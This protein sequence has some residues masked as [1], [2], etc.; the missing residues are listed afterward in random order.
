MFLF[1]GFGIEHWYL[2]VLLKMLVR[3]LELNRSG[4]SFALEPALHL[5]RTEREQMVLFYQRG[6]RIEILDVEVGDFLQELRR[7]FEAAGGFLEAAATISQRPRIFISYER[8]DSGTAS[9][10]FN[11]LQ[12]A[13]FEVWLDEESLQGGEEWNEIIEDQLK[14]CDYVVLLHSQNLVE[15]RE[16]YINKEIA[17][18]LDRSKFFRGIFLI[19]LLMH[20]LSAKDGLEKIKNLDQKPLRADFFD[21]DVAKLITTIRRDFQL[22]GR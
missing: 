5:D 16:G 6:T 17:L 7:R 10:L 9:Q 13:N 20:G 2:R 4:V 18:A 15:K 22:R 19:P 12:K 14:A 1:V 3:T 11:A 8:R 21:E